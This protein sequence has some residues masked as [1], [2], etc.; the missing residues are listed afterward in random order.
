MAFRSGDRSVHPKI[1]AFAV[2]IPDFLPQHPQLWIRQ[3][4]AQFA[5]AGIVAERTMYYHFVSR[6]P[7]DVLIQLAD[8][9]DTEEYIY[10]PI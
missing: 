9:I 1:S 8:I 2:K 5:L 4:N 7:P 3:A 10:R 6:L